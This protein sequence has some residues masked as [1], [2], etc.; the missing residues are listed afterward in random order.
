MKLATAILLL[1]FAMPA[2]ADVESIPTEEEAFLNVIT[3]VAPA[4]IVELLGEPD[5]TIILRNEESGEVVGAIVHYRYIT[6]NSEGEYYK[7][8]ELNYLDGRL[9]MVLFSNSDFEE[10]TIAA[11]PDD[12]GECPATC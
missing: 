11:R 9:V 7:T 5:E 8:T 4:R 1:A 6:T 12:G 10:T 2:L 3:Q